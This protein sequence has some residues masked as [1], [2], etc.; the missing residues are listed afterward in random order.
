MKPNINPFPSAESPRGR[1]FCFAGFMDIDNEAI[2]LLREQIRAEQETAAEIKRRN[3]LSEQA[4]RET[5]KARTAEQV[6]QRLVFDVYERVACLAETLPRSLAEISA[7]LLGVDESLKAIDGRLDRTDEILLIWL[8]GRKNGNK[9]R[10]EE[11]QAE[12][13][14]ER[15]QG[16]LFQEYENLHALELQAAQYGSA[17]T[18]LKTLNQIKACRAKIEKLQARLDG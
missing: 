9:T 14:R 13:G 7:F 16:L 15:D 1:G 3:D 12:L 17:D 5:A 2:E 11:L 4:L 10:A 6:R 18:P 8:L